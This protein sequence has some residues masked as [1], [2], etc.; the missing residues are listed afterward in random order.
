MKDCIYITHKNKK[1]SALWYCQ[2]GTNR[3]FD[4]PGEKFCDDW[5]RC[6]DYKPVSEEDNFKLKIP[7]K[8]FKI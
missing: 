1:K 4:F 7:M 5:C 2:Y 3:S 8:E 6:S